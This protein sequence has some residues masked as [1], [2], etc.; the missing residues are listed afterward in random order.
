M[1]M[2]F[3]FFDA[4]QYTSNLRCTIQKT[5]KMG[6]SEYTQSKLG[7][8]ETISIRIGIDGQRGNYK[9]LI[10]QLL[11]TLESSAFKVNKA[12]NYFYINPKPL[13]DELGIDYKTRNVLYEMI[14]LNEEK[15]IYK[16]IKKEVK[17]VAEN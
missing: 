13:F 9:N 14:A 7:I 2:D 8:N 3:T 12:G 16:L 10:M 6:F 17:V 5:G 1:D 4:S 11:S 15:R